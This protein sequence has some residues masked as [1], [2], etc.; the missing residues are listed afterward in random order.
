MSDED[1]QIAGTL[2]VRS[3]RECFQAVCNCP[4]SIAPP[5][6]PLIDPEPGIR[7]HA[8]EIRMRI[9]RRVLDNAKWDELVDLAVERA[10]SIGAADYGNASYYKSTRELTA[11]GDCE[12]ADLIFYEHIPCTREGSSWNA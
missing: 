2:T 1:D 8:S 9:L 5:S 11:E 6:E 4:K 7:Q 3:C 10:T 12:L